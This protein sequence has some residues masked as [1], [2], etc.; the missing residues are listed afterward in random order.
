MQH[1]MTQAVQHALD[2]HRVCTETVQHCLTAGGAHAAPDHIRLLLDCAQI[3][4]TSADFMT[5]DS[6]LHNRV[7]GVCADVCDA[8]AASC[9]SVSDD[10]MMRACIEACERCAASC[11]AMAA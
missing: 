3:C 5:R 7:C 2:C 9:R 1:D 10:A 11:R 8:C 6:S 4:A